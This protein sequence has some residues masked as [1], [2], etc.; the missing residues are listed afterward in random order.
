[1]IRIG[2]VFLLGTVF[3]LL[4]VVV[5]L[6]ENLARFEFQ[7]KSSAK[8]E[9]YL[10]DDTSPTELIALQEQIRS[11]PGMQS[12]NYHRKEEAL[13]EMEGILGSQLIGLE[14]NNPF[15]SSLV[16]SITPSFVSLENFEG[17]ATALK[18]TR[19]VEEI[20]YRREWLARQEKTFLFL[21]NLSRVLL[22]TTSLAAILALFFL[23]RRSL[24]GRRQEFGI[25]R[26][27]G[28]GWRYVGLSIIGHG[29]LL[30]AIST[31][32]AYLAL[33][34]SWKTLHLLPL[35]LQFLSISSGIVIVTSI[36][37]AGAASSFILANRV[38]K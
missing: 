5:L 13:S 15:P 25:F 32:I 33:Y 19:C 22:L 8:L 30:T 26:L 24:Q 2:N 14:E 18:S 28:G 11:L 21:K 36:L 16:L 1:M 17:M 6:R 3:L 9:L 12:I 38:I 20:D 10:R 37:F 35:E 27:F 23:M 4:G 31:C 34:L 29:I 7:S